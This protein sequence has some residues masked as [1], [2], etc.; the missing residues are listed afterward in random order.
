MNAP[1]CD[2]SA[3]SLPF[4][5]ENFIEGGR[6]GN[7]LI[8]VNVG[9]PRCGHPQKHNDIDP[10]PKKSEPS[11]QEF[12]KACRRTPSEINN[13]SSRVTA[14]VVV[15]ALGLDPLLRHQG[16]L[17]L[18]GSRARPRQLFGRPLEEL[19]ERLD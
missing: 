14:G 18:L 13:A 9:V 8:G 5:S 15:L 11:W 2:D 10:G 12:L 7:C 19:V 17:D 3:S 16:L 1:R 4:P 6:R